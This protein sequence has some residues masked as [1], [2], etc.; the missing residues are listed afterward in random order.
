MG[1][2]ELLL[3]FHTSE[4]QTGFNVDLFQVLETIHQKSEVT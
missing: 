3:T 1:D 2:L 4:D